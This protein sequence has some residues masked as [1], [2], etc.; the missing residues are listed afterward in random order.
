VAINY[1]LG[2]WPALVRCGDD[3]QLEIDKSVAERALPDQMPVTR[4][5]LPCTA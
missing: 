1:A 2:R 4:G 3:G 5:R